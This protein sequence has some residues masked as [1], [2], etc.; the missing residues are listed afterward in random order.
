MLDMH[1]PKSYWGAAFLTVAYLID[2]ISSC[3]LYFKTLL[4]ALSSPFSTSK[5]VSIK[6]FS[7]GCYV[8]IHGPTR[9]GLDPY[10]LKYAFVGY[11]PT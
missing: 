9:G 10:S 11:S 2:R 6:V 3:A 5:G 7:C 1:V 8:H 4:E